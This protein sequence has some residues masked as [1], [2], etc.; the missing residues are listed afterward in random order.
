MEKRLIDEN[1]EE[2]PQAKKTPLMKRFRRWLLT[3]ALAMAI[4]PLLWTYRIKIINNA[5]DLNGTYIVCTWHA[6]I[7]S[8]IPYA[9]LN[10]DK[11]S[12]LVSPSRDGEAAVQII[13][14][15]GLSV[16]RGSSSKRSLTALRELLR[17]LSSGQWIGILVDGPR[18]PRYV[19]K[20]GPSMLSAMAETP[21]L[22]IAFVPSSYWALKSWDR[23]IIPR[24]FTTIE[25]RLGSL[26]PPAHDTN[27]DSLE[28]HTDQITNALRLLWIQRPS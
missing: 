24:P 11:G 1:S 20:P 13:Q 12:I 27:R 9:R 18:G 15:L 8:S 10:R 23:S 22:P 17:N 6:D 19:C 25:V 7:L 16:I 14:R 3:S 21:V 28:Q 5:G 4:R 26:I 2:R